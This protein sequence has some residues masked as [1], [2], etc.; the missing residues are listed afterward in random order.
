LTQQLAVAR[1]QLDTRERKRILREKLTDWMVRIEKLRHTIKQNEP[2]PTEE[3][4]SLTK[5]L[6]KFAGEKLEPHQVKLL[7]SSAGLPIQ[8]SGLHGEQRKI[9][10]YLRRFEL[11]LS[12]F[13]Q[14]L[15]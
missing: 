10:E 5:E 2:P 15:Q 13:S 8:L 6:F 9:W 11:R 7:K 4:K 14:D 12:E 3:F 1:Q